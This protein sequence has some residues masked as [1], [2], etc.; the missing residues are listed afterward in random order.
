MAFVLLLASCGQVETTNEKTQEAADTL[1]LEE[2]DRKIKDIFFSLPSPLELSSLFKNQGVNYQIEKLHDTK[3]RDTYV[4]TIKKSLNLGIYGA[5]LSY[6]GLFA[7]YED[8]IRYFSSSQILAE[9]LGIGQTFQKEFITRLEQNADNQ[10]TL[11]QVISDFFLENDSY[12]KSTNQAN[13]STYVLIGGWIEGM[14]I[15]TNM[16]TADSVGNGIKE[17]IIG[18][19]SSLDNLLLLLNNSDKSIELNE[20]RDKMHQLREYYNEIEYSEMSPEE[21]N[22]ESAIVLYS[23]NK[24]G[25]MSDSTFNKVYNSISEIRESITK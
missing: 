1:A 4:T 13:V 15:G 25:I 9:E 5:D 12:L 3:K 23:D 11:L 16:I 24:A 17:V 10:D 2:K 8:A 14:Y 18:Q 22:D 21:T 6:S 19:L 7:Q 20:L